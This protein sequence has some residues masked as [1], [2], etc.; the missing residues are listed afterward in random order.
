MNNTTNVYLNVTVEYNGDVWATTDAVAE[1][2]VNALLDYDELSIA[3]ITTTAPV[4][5]AILTEWN[6]TELDDD[7][8]DTLIRDLENAIENICS[9]YRIRP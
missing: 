2:V 5:N 7:E 4:W 9:D 6:L 3:S 1:E 8:K